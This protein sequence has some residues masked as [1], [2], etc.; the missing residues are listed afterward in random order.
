MLACSKRFMR[1]FPA[2][3]T[4]SENLAADVIG[5]RRAAESKIFTVAKFFA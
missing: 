1:L 5:K 4:G 2:L 3:T